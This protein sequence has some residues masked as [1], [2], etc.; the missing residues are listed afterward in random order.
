MAKDGFTND[1]DV[2]FKPEQTTKVSQ[3]PANSGN[4]AMPVVGTNA[5]SQWATWDPNQWWT[6]WNLPADPRPSWELWFDWVKQLKNAVPALQQASTD[7]QTLIGQFDTSLQ[8]VRGM[9]ADL[10]EWTGPSA[11]TM[12]QSLDRLENSIT[13]KANAIRDNPAKLNDVVQT[14]ND[15]VAPMTALDA[16]YQKVLQDLNACRQVALR[17]RPIML[18]IAMQML[19][20]GTA[21][22]NSVQTDNLAPQPTPPAG[23][24][25]TDAQAGNTQQFANVAGSSGLTDPGNVSQGQQVAVAHAPTVAGASGITD[26]GTVTAATGQGMA[27]APG[28]AISAGG[29]QGTEV[30]MPGDSAAQV[31]SSPTLASSSAGTLAPMPAVPTG[32]AAP[33]GTAPTVT[34]AGAGFV[35]MTSMPMGGG[36][37]GGGIARTPSVASTGSLTS[38]PVTPAGAPGSA[39]RIGSN[40]PQPAAPQQ[41]PGHTTDPVP[42]AVPLMAPPI[43]GRAGASGSV[44]VPSGLAGRTAGANRKTVITG[45]PQGR[46]RETLRLRDESDQQLDTEA[47]DTPGA[48]SGVVSGRPP[49]A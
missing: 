14:I 7:W 11:Q 48:G 22:E 43:A 31:A 18:N 24:E 1:L 44:A 39:S 29:G 2:D 28:V 46:Q 13:T 49:V 17:G 16:E 32:A 34:G 36:G 20:A 3:A 21:L 5:Q 23:I 42:V 19:K 4:S 35:P 15:A 41:Q 38:V 12:A 27:H 25:L 26:P 37:G 6:D 33:M 10:T 40:L 45:V 30:T 8:N 47:F 9:R